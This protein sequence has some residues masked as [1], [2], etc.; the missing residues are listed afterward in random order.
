MLLHTTSSSSYPDPAFDYFEDG[1]GEEGS[2]HPGANGSLYYY[3]EQVRANTNY[4]IIIM[5]VILDKT[6]CIVTPDLTD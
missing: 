4:I 1:G 5:D 3:Y 6:V 2:R